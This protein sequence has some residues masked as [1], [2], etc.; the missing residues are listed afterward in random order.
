MAAS[1]DGRMLRVFIG[2]EDDWDGEPLYRAILRRAHELGL[3]TA[4]A[5]RGDL[6]YG[7][8]GVL[9]TKA[10]AD[11]PSYLPVVVE[12]IDVTEKVE[13]LLPALQQMVGEGLISVEAVRVRRYGRA[14]SSG[15]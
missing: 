14:Q 1:E 7:G 5:R 15:K 2:E 3:A 11:V 4:A 12:I 10:V 8:G 13:A 6:G 9:R